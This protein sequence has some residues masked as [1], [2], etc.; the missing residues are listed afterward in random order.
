MHT[1]L[2]NINVNE[3]ISNPTSIE[4]IRLAAAISIARSITENNTVANIP[5]RNCD[6]AAQKHSFDSVLLISA[7]TSKPIARR[8]IDTPKSTHKNAGVIAIIAEKLR[9]TAIIPIIRLA[10]IENNVH[11]H[12][13][14]HSHTVINITSNTLYSNQ[15]GRVIIFINYYQALIVDTLNNKC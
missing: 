13:F 8:P 10:A 5:A 9:K 14:L 2:V 11:S 7:A 4:A 6:T 1:A 12:L 15:S 3:P